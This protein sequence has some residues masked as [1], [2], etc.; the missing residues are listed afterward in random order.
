MRDVITQ[1][2]FAVIVHFIPIGF[3]RDFRFDQNHNYKRQV[4]ICKVWNKSDLLGFS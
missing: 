1:G 2:A 3:N 4:Y